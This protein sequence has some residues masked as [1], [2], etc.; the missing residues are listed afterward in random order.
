[1]TEE[2]GHRRTVAT[3]ERQQYVNNHPGFSF[4]IFKKKKQKQ[5]S[6]RREEDKQTKYQMEA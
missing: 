1:M 3:A 5:Y 6:R 4:L 2:Y